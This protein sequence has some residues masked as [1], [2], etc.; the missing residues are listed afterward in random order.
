[1]PVQALVAERTVEMMTALRVT[2]AGVAL[3]VRLILIW[4]LS[5]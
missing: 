2:A 4:A 5:T 1:M 3:R